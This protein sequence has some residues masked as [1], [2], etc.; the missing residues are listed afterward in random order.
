M[1]DLLAN[2]D[3][4]GTQCIKHFVILSPVFGSGSFFILFHSVLLAPSHLLPFALVRSR[5]TFCL[6][7]A[8][9]NEQFR[10]T[11]KGT[12]KEYSNNSDDDDDND[13]DEQKNVIHTTMKK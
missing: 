7:R 13:N 1:L 11:K 8:R 2:D 12:R 4:D 6:E 9:T 5:F 10:K 3:D